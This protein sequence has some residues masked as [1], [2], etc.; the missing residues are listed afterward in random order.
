MHLTPE[1]D[2]FWRS[3]PQIFEKTFESE[4][5]S[6]G[7][8]NS[9]SPLKNLEQLSPSVSETPTHRTKSPYTSGIDDLD[10]EENDDDEEP[11]WEKWLQGGS[12]PP[13]TPKIYISKYTSEWLSFYVRARSGTER[14]EVSLVSE[15]RGRVPEA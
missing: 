4:S 14:P 3:S 7:S 9:N 8:I 5:E 12:P 2:N 11:T 1:K 6:D 10:S 13:D 15:A